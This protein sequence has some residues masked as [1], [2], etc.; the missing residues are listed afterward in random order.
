MRTDSDKEFVCRD[1][2]LARLVGGY[3][4]SVVCHPNVHRPDA[5]QRRDVFRYLRG[6]ESGGLGQARF[7]NGD[8]I[9]R[10]G[11]VG[12]DR[13]SC[14]DAKRRL[15]ESSRQLSRGHTKYRKVDPSFDGLAL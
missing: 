7:Q 4:G 15:L 6:R 12:G 1:D 3:K 2:V 5:V 14:R 11:C 8:S 9:P 13:L 10:Q